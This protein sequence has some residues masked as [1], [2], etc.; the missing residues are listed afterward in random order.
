MMSVFG[1]NDKVRQEIVCK[2]HDYDCQIKA[3]LRPIKIKTLFS[4]HKFVTCNSAFELRMCL[5]LECSVNRLYFA[6]FL[7]LCA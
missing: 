4:F 7:R 6:I 1:K 3:E 5:A 2:K